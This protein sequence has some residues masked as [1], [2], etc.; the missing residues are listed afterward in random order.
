MALPKQPTLP[1][2]VS[3]TEQELNFIDESPPGLFPENQDS[4]LGYLIRKTFT[5][6]V[7]VIADQMALMY[8]ERFVATSTQYLDVWEKEVGL[9]VNPPGAS[10]TRRRNAIS[11][12]LIK[13]P[14]TRARRDATIESFIE[15]T[16]GAATEILPPGVVLSAGGVTM[17]S[18]LTSA[19][20]NYTVTEKVDQFLYLVYI[21]PAIALDIVGLRRELDRITPAGI[22]YTVIN[23]GASFSTGAVAVSGGEITDAVR[24]AAVSGDG[25]TVDSSFGMYEATTN[26]IPNSDTFSGWPTPFGATAA[27]VTDV[28]KFGTGAARMTMTQDAVANGIWWFMP[29][30]AV[31]GATAG[32]TFTYSVWIYGEGSSIGKRMSIDLRE[33]GGASADN[34]TLVYFTVVA[35]WQRVSVTRTIAYNDRTFLAAFIYGASDRAPWLTTG[36]HIVIDGAQLEEKPYATPYTP[37]TRAAATVTVPASLMGQDVTQGWFATRFRVG[38]K[39]NPNASFAFLFGV[40]TENQVYGYLTDY[41]FY[42]ARYTPTPDGSGNQAGGSY[43]GASVGIAWPGGIQ[44]G[45]VHTLAFQWT[46]KEIMVSLDG[47]PFVRVNHVVKFNV[48]GAFVPFYVGGYGTLPINGDVFWAAG[49]SGILTDEDVAYINSFGNVDKYPGDFPGQPRFSWPADTAG[50]YYW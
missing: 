1:I 26:L 48:P 31:S 32:R 24:A 2:P 46:P 50:Y 15:S 27:V 33:S 23:S 18:G 38:T 9:P 22:S 13:G 10:V 17:Y 4:N 42:I 12:R 11:T 47:A 40:G 7:K 36:D 21:N 25:R 41:G 37:T 16:L 14:F 35:G 34:D 45:S 8:S 49:G 29:T 20:Y 3:Y 39:T 5:D 43:D 30:V 6:Q 28:K 19:K 44:V